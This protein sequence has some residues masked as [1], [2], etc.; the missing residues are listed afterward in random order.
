ML[1]RMSRYGKRPVPQ[2]KAIRLFTI[3]ER[4]CQ[5]DRPMVSE[6]MHPQGQDRTVPKIDQS[7][8]DR[9]FDQQLFDP[10]QRIPF[11][12]TAEIQRHA[13]SGKSHSM[14]RRL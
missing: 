12:K 6:R 8:S 13:C 9:L 4:I 11:R 5:P 7:R 14:T 1:G 10:F 2:L 3:P